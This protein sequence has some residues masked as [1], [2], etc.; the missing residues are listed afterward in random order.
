MFTRIL[1]PVDG[2]E[3]SIKA[4]AQA[5]EYAKQTG[6]AMV[7]VYAA[8]A[9][10]SVA[11]EDFIPPDFLTPQRF[12]EATERTAL[13]ILAPVEQSCAKAGVACKTLHVVDDTPHEAIIATAEKQKCDLIVMA[14]HGRRG[15]TGLLLGSE[16]TKVLTHSK[17]PVLVLR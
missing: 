1:F 6:A 3:P 16:T 8:P 12:A 14:S 15:L 7:A 9:Y 10:R 2:S 13:R 11:Y 5:V 17:I 4:T